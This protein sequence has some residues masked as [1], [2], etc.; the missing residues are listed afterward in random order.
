MRQK[1]WLDIVGILGVLTAVLLFGWWALPRAVVAMPSRVRLHLPEELLQ[2]VSTPL[3][4]ALPAPKTAVA[5]LPLPTISLPT[6][7]LPPTNTTVLTLTYAP[8]SAGGTPVLSEAEVAVPTPTLAPSAIPTSVPTPLPAQA[9]IEG[10]QIIP[11]KFNNCGPANLTINLNHYGAAAEQLDIAAQIR[12]TYDDRNVSPHELAAYVNNETP[13]Q[14]AV[15]SGGNLTMLKRLLANGFPVVIEKGLLP[16]DWQGWMG[17][18]L[19]LIGYD[20]TA[21]EFIA[22]DTFLGPWDSSG[23]H[24]SYDFIEEHW[25][26]F[27][28]TFY[29][30]YPPEQE[31][32]LMAVLGPEMT[33]PQQMWLHAVR[34]AQTEVDK[35]HNNAFAWFN[36]GTSL[37]HLAQL[38]DNTTYYGHA[39]AAYDQART[40]GLPWRMLWYQFQPYAAYLAT[41]RVDDV[42]T[43]AEATLS[44]S[45]GDYLEESFYYRGLA[46]AILGDNGRA[47]SNLQKAIA[48]NPTYTA[49]AAALEQLE[50]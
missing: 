4:T 31:T 35:N 38:T 34:L 11:Q 20:D 24:E 22:L 28:Y 29:V 42:L 13:L 47:Q 40:I 6:T 27:N 3:P 12:P 37:T 39:A 10:L 43:L 48:L 41:G 26:H 45:G 16:N 9:Y 1:W 23:L 5:I 33:D 2:W 49:A 25:Q 32:A 21:Q 17:H 44:S 36:L 30:V 18:Y 15:F 50:P 46:Y 14:A 8:I 7:A 19:T